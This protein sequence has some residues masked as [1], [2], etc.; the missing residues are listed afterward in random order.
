MI[1]F[2]FILLVFGTIG[3]F[4][5][6]SKNVVGVMIKEIDDLLDD[7]DKAITVRT[8]II[9]GLINTIRPLINKQEDFD[10]LA[11]IGTAN[12]NVTTKTN[13]IRL[14]SKNEGLINGVLTEFTKI[15]QVNPPLRNIPAI[16]DAIADLDREK[17][18]M[19]A[20]LKKINITINDYNTRLHEFPFKVVTGILK[21][22]PRD[23]FKESERELDYMRKMK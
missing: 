2:L 3:Y 1:T 9:T 7:M 5:F 21:L 17:G 14:R 4:I 18:K 15:I 22:K 6:V 20:R 16:S 10:R 13:D 23:T 19:D 11:R 8:E 12:A